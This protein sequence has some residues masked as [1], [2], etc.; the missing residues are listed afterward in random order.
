MISRRSTSSIERYLYR[1]NDN[2][3]L[4]NVGLILDAIAALPLRRGCCDLS[5]AKRERA[6]LAVYEIPALA[7]LYAYDSVI[8]RHAIV[9]RSWL[10]GG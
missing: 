2:A 3:P 6:A 5:Y 10:V 1:K 9:H 4:N 8:A 7:I